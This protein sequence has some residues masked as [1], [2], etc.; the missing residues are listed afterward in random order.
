MHLIALKVGEIVKS[1]S[2]VLST[3]RHVALL[4]QN[5]PL[6]HFNSFL[7]LQSILLITLMV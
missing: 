5:L 1:Q 7:K 4:Q 3:C 2:R 6:Q